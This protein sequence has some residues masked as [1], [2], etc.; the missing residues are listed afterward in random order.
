[1]KSYQIQDYGQPLVPVET[2][3]PVPTGSE[4][5]LRIV[6]SG[7][8]HTDLHLIEGGYDLG[9]G[10]RL[11][12]KD[13]GLVLPRT[14]GHEI[15][16]KVVAPGP[17]AAIAT[18]DSNYLVYPW[19]GC[20]RCVACAAGEEH[21]CA[22]PRFLGLQ[23]DGG[24]SDHVVVPHP[25]YLLDIG[26]L[27]AERVAPY[28]CSGLTTYSALKKAGRAIE[29]SD[30][31]VI[32]AGGL[33]LMAVHLLRLMGGRGA[34]VIDIDPAKRQAALDAGARVALDGRAVDIAAQLQESLGG[35]SHVV[36]DL[37]G[38]AATAQLAIDSL[39][40]GGKYI[41]I[42]LFGGAIDLPLPTLP[43]RAISVTGSFVGSVAELRELLELVK[44]AGLPDFPTTR[45]ALHDA[46][47]NL[48]LLH[49]GKVVGRI[50][51]AS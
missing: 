23:R 15:V 27:P 40:K 49:D 8:C 10:R 19:I 5:L 48:G 14:P 24:F 22:Q 35:G 36:I 16:G 20:G 42:G 17:D 2:A 7:I 46:N 45:C 34:V 1:M 38:S 33:G 31:V 47:H 28:A 11:S 39:A 21:L 26:D 41:L 37:V 32:G 44:A 30:V 6:A 12:F 4:V 43:L 29:R 50:V 25:R 9:G 13:R 18:G 51:M 3:T